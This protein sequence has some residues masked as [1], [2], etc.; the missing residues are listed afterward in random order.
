MQII[1]FAN[2]NHKTLLQECLNWS[3]NSHIRFQMYFTKDAKHIN[4]LILNQDDK[5]IFVNDLKVA[6]I[7]KK[8]KRKFV[9]IKNDWSKGLE[10]ANF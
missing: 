10:N 5:L 3:K 6:K 9:F 4:R 1:I 2:K 7:L 8:A